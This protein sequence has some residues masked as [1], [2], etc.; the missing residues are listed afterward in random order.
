MRELVK[1][2]EKTAISQAEQLLEK[3][4]KEITELRM[5]EAELDKLSHSEDQI[6]FLQVG[7]LRF[8]FSSFQ[9]S[10]SPQ[11]VG[12]AWFVSPELPVSP[13]S[14]CAVSVASSHL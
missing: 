13:S 7:L 12:L 11:T 9:D 14:T 1:A 3:I 4:Q 6:H 5:N 10:N 2:Q 8:V